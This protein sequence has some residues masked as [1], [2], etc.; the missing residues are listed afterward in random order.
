MATTVDLR[1]QRANLWE[2]AKSI[3]T[4]A[5]KEKRELTAEEREQWDRINAEIDH[6][7]QRIDREERIAAIDNEMDETPAPVVRGNI[8]KFEQHGQNFADQPES[9]LP[10]SD[11]YKRSFRSYLLNGL[12]GM[13]AEQRAILQPYYG[14]TPNNIQTRALLS[15]GSA[16]A[17]VAEDFYRR[18]VEAL[19]TWG[20]MRQARTTKIATSTGASMPIPLADDTHNKG[21]ILS[22]G[23]NTNTDG[24]DPEFG[25][26]TL[27]AYMYTSKM[28]RVPI[29]MLQ[30]PAFDIEGWLANALAT[31]IGR[32]TNDH[33]TTGNGTTEPEGI[34]TAAG[35]G[36]LDAALDIDYY[37]L[38]SLEHSVDPAYRANAQWMF[39]DTTLAVIKQMKAVEDG[40]PLWLPG[41][42][43]TAP[44]TLL[45]YPYVINQSMPE[46]AAEEKGV[47]FGDFSYYFIRDVMAD[48][49][50]LRLEERFAEYLQVG[51]LGFFRTDGL[52]ASPTDIEGSSEQ[53]AN[54][55]APVKYLQFAAESA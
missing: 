45:G 42:A 25:T 21:E 37:D 47:L 1:Q 41:L 5:E 8:A 34:V 32:I 20:G 44:D 10:N 16:G 2:E 52:F 3:H 54:E 50:I 33:Y 23:S 49:R 15:T 51:F 24:T 29:Q 18:L 28:V 39:H 26:K 27:G 55:S 31:R 4:L 46:A 22:E 7:K 38:I 35:A 36:V 11:E 30:D 13:R 48:T 12:G 17:L 40:R 53:T 19:K 14:A 9:P 6:L 43:V